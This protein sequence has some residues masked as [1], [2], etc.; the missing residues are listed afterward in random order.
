[1]WL[2]IR[3][4]LRSNASVP[5]SSK[6]VVFKA[7]LFRRRSLYFLAMLTLALSAKSASASGTKR[8]SISNPT[9]AKQQKSEDLS[10]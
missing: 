10:F 6:N 5:A 1:M 2:L 3:L 4:F 9:L 7:L 8:E